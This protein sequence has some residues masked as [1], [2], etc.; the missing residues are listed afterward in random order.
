MRLIVAAAVLAFAVA[1]PA[2]ACSVD[3]TYRVPTNLELA[4]DAELIVL[5]RVESGPT[6]M[7]FQDASLLVTPLEVLKG[8]LP[9]GRELKLMGMIAEPRFAVKSNP[10]E[11]EEAHPLAY[12]GGC[13]I[14]VREGLVSPVLRKTC[15]KGVRR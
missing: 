7:A 2:Y 14:H 4:A 1:P 13:V 5:A 8:Q 3:D 12:I 11:L 15:G 10:A 9:V 6:D